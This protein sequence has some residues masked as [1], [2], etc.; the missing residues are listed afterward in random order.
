[1]LN[2]WPDI[3]PPNCELA[4]VRKLNRLLHQTAAEERNYEDF[5]QDSAV[6]KNAY[7][8]I[9]TLAHSTTE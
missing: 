6:A 7:N 4:S 2:Y 5:Q 3:F 1:V 9:G 8:T